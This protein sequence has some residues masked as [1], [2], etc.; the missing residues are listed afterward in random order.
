MSALHF[1]KVYGN[2][3]DFAGFDLDNG[4]GERFPRAKRLYDDLP[5]LFEVDNTPD[6]S[7]VEAHPNTGTRM[8][9]YDIIDSNDEP[10]FEVKNNRTKKEIWKDV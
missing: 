7:V 1:L 4:F 2:S 5:E 10:S 9:M 6:S 3:D 8:S